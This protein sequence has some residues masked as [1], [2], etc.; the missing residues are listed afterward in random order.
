MPAG[1]RACHGSL[2]VTRR[3]NKPLPVSAQCY[4]CVMVRPSLDRWARGTIYQA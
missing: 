3:G 1:S 4:V 2:L